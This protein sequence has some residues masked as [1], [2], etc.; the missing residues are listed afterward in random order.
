MQHFR[1]GPLGTDSADE[2]LVGLGTVRVG[3]ASQDG[4]IE[5][6]YE[7]P[8]PN[9]T[10]DPHVREISPLGHC[11]V[12]VLY[13]CARSVMGGGSQLMAMAPGSS[14]T[15]AQSAQNPLGDRRRQDRE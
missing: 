1:Y 6:A 5:V 7:T 15:E 13:Q 12:C 8:D 4:P 2:L 10:D 9:S 14:G 11:A 3:I